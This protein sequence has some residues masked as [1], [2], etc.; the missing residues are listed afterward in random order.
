MSF[1]I[2]TSIIRQNDVIG[3]IKNTFKSWTSARDTALADRCLGK[4]QRKSPELCS[5]WLN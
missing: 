5:N 1:L 3:L 2:P 4:S